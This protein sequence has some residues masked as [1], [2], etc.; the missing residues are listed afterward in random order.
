MRRNMDVVVAEID[1]S[2]YSRIGSL[3]K[4]RG[5]PTTKFFP[6][7]DSSTGIAYRDRRTQEDLLKWVEEQIA[8]GSKDAGIS[9]PNTTGLGV[10]VDVPMERTRMEEEEEEDTDSGAFLTSAILFLLRFLALV[11]V[12]ATIGYYLMIRSRR[13]PGPEEVADLEGSQ[14]L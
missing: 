7:G 5:F 9:N 2:R 14:P 12:I 10:Q 4:I 1:A 3:H 13:T 8:A 11:S 6:R